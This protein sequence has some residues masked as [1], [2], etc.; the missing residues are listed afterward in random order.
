MVKA[1]TI[2]QYIPFPYDRPMGESVHN[3]DYAINGS[4]MVRL[5]VAD[6]MVRHLGNTLDER[7]LAEIPAYLHPSG[8]TAAQAKKATK[9]RSI[10]EWS[11]VR[12][13]LLRVYDR[14]FR[15]YYGRGS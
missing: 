4:D 12:S 6:R 2:R 9:A 14:I 5:A 15:L 10:F 8:I 3:F 1:E 11:P 13:V 7:T